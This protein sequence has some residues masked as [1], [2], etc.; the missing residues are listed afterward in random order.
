MAGWR[1]EKARCNNT[2]LGVVKVVNTIWGIKGLLVVDTCKQLSTKMMLQR[3]YKRVS[4]QQKECRR[5][6]ER[7]I[8]MVAVQI[9]SGVLAAAV[10]GI[11][12]YRRKQKT[13]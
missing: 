3:T 11:I 9:V 12:I 6:T 7:R 13:V 8:V 5:S 4:P 2:G 10:L 1:A